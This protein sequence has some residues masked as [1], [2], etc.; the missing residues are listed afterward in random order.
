MTPLVLALLVDCSHW[1]GNGAGVYNL[2]NA[3]SE[4]YAT[5]IDGAGPGALRFGFRIDTQ[6]LWNAALLAQYDAL[7][8][9]AREHGI[10]LLG[11]VLYESTT[12]GQADWNDDPSGTGMN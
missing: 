2:S 3:L 6:Q 4:P 8:E 5:A 7:V 11:I 1:G 10:D 12:L 9:K